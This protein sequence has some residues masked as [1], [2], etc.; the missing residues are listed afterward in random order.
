MLCRRTEKYACMII[1]AAAA[2]SLAM[3]APAA[4][5]P[6]RGATQPQARA[7]AHQGAHG[8]HGAGHPQHAAPAQATPPKHGMSNCA[9]CKPGEPRMP[10]C[11]EHGAQGATGH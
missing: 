8:A 9:C 2:L 4:A 1:D 3:G 11:K 7:G 5:Q 10:C 6:A